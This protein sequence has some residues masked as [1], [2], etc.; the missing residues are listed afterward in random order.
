MRLPRMTTRRW[1][2]VVALCARCWYYG[3]CEAWRARLRPAEC[4]RLDGTACREIDAN[5]PRPGPAT[6]RW[7]G[8]M[9]IS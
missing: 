1:M 5:N 4:C 7:R 2:I 9:P 8:I 6:D 3:D